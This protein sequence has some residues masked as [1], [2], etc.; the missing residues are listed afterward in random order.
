M[1]AK[2]RLVR[3]YNYY[4]NSVSLNCFILAYFLAIFRFQII[5]ALFRDG[6]LF[7]WAGSAILGIVGNPEYGESEWWVENK[8]KNKQN[9]FNV[10]MKVCIFLMICVMTILHVTA[11]MFISC[12]SVSVLRYMPMVSREGTT[13]LEKI[14]HNSDRIQPETMDIVKQLLEMCSQ[15]NQFHSSPEETR[16]RNR[17]L[18]NQWL[19]INLYN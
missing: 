9:L 2:F 3:M 4:N 12:T 8:T 6:S 18:V 10:H 19:Y 13:Y 14:L 11:W 7:W 16:R 5:P 15:S 17:R 1:Y